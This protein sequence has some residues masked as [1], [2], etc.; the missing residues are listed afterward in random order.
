MLVEWVAQAVARLTPTRIVGGSRP[1]PDALSL[2]H[3]A[4]IVPLYD[5]EPNLGEE[6][7]WPPYS[8]MPLPI[9][10]AKLVFHFGLGFRFI[11]M[12]ICLISSE[13]SICICGP[14]TFI[15]IN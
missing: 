13:S 12:I 2:A 11:T 10:D 15:F 5:W 14:V 3:S 1:T 6:R 7:N 8:A 4:L 9:G